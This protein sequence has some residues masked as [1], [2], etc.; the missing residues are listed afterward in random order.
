MNS[1]TRGSRI[2][3]ELKKTPDGCDPLFSNL[4]TETS[5]L[6]HKWKKS[7]C[8]YSFYDHFSIFPFFQR[9]LHF[10]PLFWKDI[11]SLNWSHSK[12]KRDRRMRISPLFKGDVLVSVVYNNSEIF[13]R[14]SVVKRPQKEKKRKQNR[15]TQFY[16]LK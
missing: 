11:L 1:Y 13:P 16:W 9:I 2:R 12:T 14:L 15:A 7:A 8:K 10:F 5:N 6:S 3:Y 4:Y